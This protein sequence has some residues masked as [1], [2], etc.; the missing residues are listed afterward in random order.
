VSEQRWQHTLDKITTWWLKNDLF[1][2]AWIFQFEAVFT[3]AYVIRGA[4]ARARLYARELGRAHAHAQEAQ[5][6]AFYDALLR[7]QTDE[8]IPPEERLQRGIVA[9]CERVVDYQGV[10]GP[11]EALYMGYGVKVKDGL[12]EHSCVADQASTANALLDAVETFPQ[13]P[14]VA[15]WLACVRR[16]ADWVLREFALANGG[17]GVGIFGHRWNPIPEYWCATSLFA[18]ALFKLAR[19]TGES[20]YRERALASLDWLARFDH[21]HVEIP[22]FED[23]PT[24]VILYATEGI[25]E[26]LEYLAETQGIER[27]RSHP[28]A[29]KYR[30]LAAWLVENQLPSGRWPEPIARGYRPYSVGLPWELLRLERLLGP[31]PRWRR[32]A[33]RMLNFLSRREGEAY[34]GLYNRPFAMGLAFLSFSQA[35]L[36]QAAGRRE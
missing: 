16:W 9:F 7:A 26:G 12:P 31:E 35:A 4:L 22:K 5:G 2:P 23:C 21:L 29:D 19:L 17:V 36:M 27:A 18:S 24:E 14:R 1:D 3:E 15:V 28:A 20:L 32:C 8:G 13:H 33:A 30:Q 10:Q 6:P 11:A 34:M 25:M